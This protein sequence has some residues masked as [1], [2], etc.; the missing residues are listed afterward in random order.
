MKTLLRRYLAHRRSFGYR[1]RAEG[2]DLASFV[3]FADHTV[4]GR[5]LSVPL[6]LRW[7]RIGPVLPVTV[8]NRLSA[9]R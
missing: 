8:A 7:A 5:P 4:P 3:R 6:A 9:V 2:F 1:L